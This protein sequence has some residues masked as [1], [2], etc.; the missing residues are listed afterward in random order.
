MAAPMLLLARRNRRIRGD[1]VFRDIDNPLDYLDDEA[2]IR[3]Y[4]LSRPLIHDLCEQFQNELQRPTM[5][6]HALPVSLQVMVA[7]RFYAT[8]RFQAVVGD[9]HN[10]SRPS[11]C[12][13]VKDMTQCLVN[14]ANI[15]IRMPI[16]SNELAKNMNEFSLIANM[17][18]TIGCIDGTHIRIKSP[19]V[20]EHL[21]INRKNY[22]S[23]NVQGVCDA[24]LKFINIVAKWPGGTHDA[25]IWSNSALN[26]LFETG[27]I[28]EG[29]LLG[30]SGY[31]LRPWL[32]TP[33]NNPSTK[34]EERYN[35]AH[36]R[37]R[38]SVERSFGILKSRFCCL[39]AS[40]G[41]LL[42]SPQK[43]CDIVVACVVLHNM[44]L[45]PYI[46]S[47][48]RSTSFGKN[49]RDWLCRDR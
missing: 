39:D 32:L 33:V 2:I 20:D 38:N 10:I 26:R 28:A 21:Y 22:H 18:N 49:S 31:P 12:K 37:T 11:V 19:S 45:S 15:H 46:P 6:S 48:P 8:G 42:Y 40:G 23:I 17:P 5:R 30:D 27:R 24:S 44:H 43:A 13:L 7:L 36:I 16:T 3:R 1:R 35:T 25:F 41:S 47:R 29:W 9:V 34:A 14:V 4:R